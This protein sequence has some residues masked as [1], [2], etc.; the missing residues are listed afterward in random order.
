MRKGFNSAMMVLC[1]I[2]KVHGEFKIGAF[3]RQHKLPQ[4]WF[5]LSFQDEYFPNS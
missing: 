1:N 2:N 4:L 5:L 3:G